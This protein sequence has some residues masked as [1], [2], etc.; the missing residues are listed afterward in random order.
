[1]TIVI[2]TINI[3]QLTATNRY[4]IKTKF[5]SCTAIENNYKK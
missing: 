5:E 3:T 4:K 1:M 2:K